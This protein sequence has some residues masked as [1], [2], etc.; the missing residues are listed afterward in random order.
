MCM[1]Y[2][3]VYMS[4][5]VCICVYVRAHICVCTAS[6][7]SFFLPRPTPYTRGKGEVHLCA[8]TPFPGAHQFPGQDPSEEDHLVP[9]SL[10]PLVSSGPAL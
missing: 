10:S 4:M 2:V 3:S 5:H 1:Y 9:L 6:Q 8:H 7:V